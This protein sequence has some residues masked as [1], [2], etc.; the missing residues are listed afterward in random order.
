MV[1]DLTT[2]EHQPLL[3]TARAILGLRVALAGRYE[4]AGDSARSVS[5]GSI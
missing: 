2:N 4:G 1:L 5:M 3:V